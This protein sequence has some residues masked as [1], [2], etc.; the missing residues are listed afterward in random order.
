MKTSGRSIILIA[1]LVALNLKTGTVRAE[2]GQTTDHPTDSPRAQRAVYYGDLNLASMS[3]QRV[4][5]QRIASAARQVCG[6]TSFRNA[7]GLSRAAAN[8]RCRDDVITEALS[9]IDETT[10]SLASAR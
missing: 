7:G 5:Q 8:Q 4:L 2:D 9:T 6:T 10:R 1:A 3:G